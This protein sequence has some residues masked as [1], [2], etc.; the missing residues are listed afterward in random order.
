MRVVVANDNCEADEVAAD[1]DAVRKEDEGEEVLE[2]VQSA[3][4]VFHQLVATYTRRCV[5][6]WLF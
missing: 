3:R 2:A 6:K 1:L 5:I 4:V